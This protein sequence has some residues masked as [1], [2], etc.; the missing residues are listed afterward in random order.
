VARLIGFYY[1]NTSGC[2][3]LRMSNISSNV[4]LAVLLEVESSAF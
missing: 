2:M 3:V 4:S 1:T